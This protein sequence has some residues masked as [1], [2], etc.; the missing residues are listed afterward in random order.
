MSLLY[1]DSHTW[2]LTFNRLQK[3]P[4][5]IKKIHYTKLTKEV[6]YQINPEKNN[7]ALANVPSALKQLNI[8]KLRWSVTQLLYITMVII[9][10]SSEEIDKVS[11]GLYHVLIYLLNGNH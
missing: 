10:G 2:Y 6:L 9:V 5:L 4:D 8:K 7:K 11:S 3:Q 1:P